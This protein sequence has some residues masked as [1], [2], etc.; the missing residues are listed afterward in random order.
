M[1]VTLLQKI[2]YQFGNRFKRL[3]YLWTQACTVPHIY[4]HSD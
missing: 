4:F 2:S 3:W 1:K